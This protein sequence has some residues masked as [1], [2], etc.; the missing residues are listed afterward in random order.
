MQL[1]N[2]ILITLV[3]AMA[4]SALLCES[5]KMPFPGSAAPGVSC[6]KQTTCCTPDAT[7]ENPAFTVERQGEEILDKD[8]K[9]IS[10]EAG[11][12]DI[13][14]LIKFINLMW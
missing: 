2:T 14:G 5:N 4:V 10:C 8:G 6:S 11:Y 3:H 7:S 9:S 13:K 1:S 12:S